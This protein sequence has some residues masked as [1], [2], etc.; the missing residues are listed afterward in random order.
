MISLGDRD[1]FVNVCEFQGEILVH[2]RQYERE[3]DK[4]FPTKKGIALKVKEWRL[5]KTN[6][7]KV[8]KELKK[9]KKDSKFESTLKVDLGSRNIALTVSDF[10][11]SI[12]VHIRK[13]F[14][15]EDKLLPTKTGIALTPSEWDVLKKEIISVDCLAKA[16][17]KT[18]L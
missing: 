16:L 14:I 10:K 1:I 7:P 5:L 15:Y 2:L 9:F 4:L 12:K 3:N 18:Q 13:Y 8:N 11:G 17:R 6:M